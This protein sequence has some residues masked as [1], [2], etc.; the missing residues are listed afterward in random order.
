MIRLITALVLTVL[1]AA[2]PG[3]QQQ[4]LQQN[5]QIE[6][7][8]MQQEYQMNSDNNETKL[9]V[10]QINS[11]AESQRYAL[12]NQGTVADNDQKERKLNE[13]VRQFDERMKQQS[14][15]LNFDIKKH[16]DEVRLKEQ[17]MRQ[18]NSK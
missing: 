16:D 3:C 9:L 15:K 7:A 4:Q 2:L 14:D 11:Q 13:Q 1:L 17:Q 6:Q 8:K 12:M 10:S 18:K 5:A